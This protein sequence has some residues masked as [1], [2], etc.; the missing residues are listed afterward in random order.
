YGR[1]AFLCLSKEKSPKEKIPNMLA[2]R[3]P[4]DARMSRRDVKLAHARTAHPDVPGSSCASR[5]A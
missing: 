4:C 5:R 1:V 3:V 2:L